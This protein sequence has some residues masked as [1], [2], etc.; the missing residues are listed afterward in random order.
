VS[1][2]IFR[3]FALLALAS[4]PALA[5][6]NFTGDWKLN[7]SKS[8]FGA[9]PG[10][11]SMTN[12]IDHAEPKFSSTSKQSSQMGEV[13]IKTSCT[14]DGKECTNEGFQGSPTKSVMNWDG[15]ALL[16]ESK[17]H[18]GDIDFTSKQKWTLSEDSKVLTIAQSI[19]TSMGDFT[20]TLVF[21]KQ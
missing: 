13:E 2:K 14:T 19:S 11:D 21:E 17:G 6:P 16:V 10:P 4:L 9:V 15:D 12:K 7:T 5:K 18:F 1:R 8:D 20:Q 3:I